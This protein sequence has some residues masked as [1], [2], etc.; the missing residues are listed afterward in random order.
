[1]YDLNFWDSSP[2]WWLYLDQATQRGVE[3][4]ATHL[5]VVRDMYDGNDAGIF[6]CYA[7]ERG[8]I[9]DEDPGVIQKRCENNGYSVLACIELGEITHG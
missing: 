1:M 5:I 4:G 7:D 2:N 3:N 9:Y 6:Y 8:G